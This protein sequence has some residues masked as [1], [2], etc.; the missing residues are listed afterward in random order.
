MII[1]APK[2][3]LIKHEHVRARCDKYNNTRLGVYLT[4]EHDEQ[5]IVWRRVQ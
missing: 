4:Q 3:Y 2:H 1:I 5:H